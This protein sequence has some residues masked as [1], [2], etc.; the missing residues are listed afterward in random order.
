MDQTAQKTDFM[1]LYI[2]SS[3]K[4]K[5]NPLPSINEGIIETDMNGLIALISE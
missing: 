4:T 3:I 2:Y 1:L 5:I